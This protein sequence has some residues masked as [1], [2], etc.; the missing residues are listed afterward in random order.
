MAKRWLVVAGVALF[1]VLS[2]CDVID[3]LY[4]PPRAVVPPDAVVA[5][6]FDAAFA[7]DVATAASL[8][9]HDSVDS[10]S[11][12]VSAFE[13]MSADATTIDTNGLTY[14]VLEITGM[15]ATVVVG[16]SMSVTVAGQT[17]VQPLDDVSV[18]LRSE[19]GQWKVCG[20]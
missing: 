11:A 14:T 3:A 12:V 16:G 7:G 9:C 17:A 6:W 1:V 18:P 5:A 19:F 8:T 20:F 4:G 13:S 2:G 10:A 15:D